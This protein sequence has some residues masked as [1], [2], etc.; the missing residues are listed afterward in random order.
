MRPLAAAAGE[1]RGTHQLC[2]RGGDPQFG[3]RCSAAQ[4]GC[5]A[6]ALVR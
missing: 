6:P 4:Q 5:C 2:L 1:E 3:S